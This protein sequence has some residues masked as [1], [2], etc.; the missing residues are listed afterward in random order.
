L[1]HK[2]RATGWVSLPGS[3]AKGVDSHDLSV[4]LLVDRFSEQLAQELNGTCLPA[5][6]PCALLCGSRLHSDRP[7]ADAGLRLTRGR[8]RST[9]RAGGTGSEAMSPCAD[10]SR[11]L[12]SVDEWVTFFAR[13]LYSN[14]PGVRQGRSS[15]GGQSEHTSTERIDDMTQAAQPSLGAL[16]PGR[17]CAACCGR[18]SRRPSGRP[19]S[20]PSCRTWPTRA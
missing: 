7:Q 19:G 12:P 3:H 10:R 1:R 18:R 14:G 20:P 4:A 8:S 16:V 5:G 2:H 17:R 13:G 9:R 15:D 11:M 6:S